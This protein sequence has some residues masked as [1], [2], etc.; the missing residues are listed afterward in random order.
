MTKY[1][2]ALDLSLSNTGI[3]IFDGDNDDITKSVLVTSVETKSKLSTQE[4]LKIIAD[5]F[6]KLIEKYPPS[7]VAIENG[8]YKF[9]KSTQTI[10]MVHGIVRYLF[11]NVEQVL[12]PPAT[13]KKFCSGR[14]NIKK[15][16]L[17]EFIKEKYHDIDFANNDQSDAYAIGITYFKKIGVLE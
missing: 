13:V 9:N 7:V 12:Y 16:A 14:G 10:Y 1:I 8:F 4:R 15:D 6:I 17:R 11:S 2:Y 3:V 5:Y